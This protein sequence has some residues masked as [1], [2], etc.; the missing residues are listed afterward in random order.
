[1]FRRFLTASL[2]LIALSAEGYV[3]QMDRNAQGRIVTI[4]WPSGSARQGVPFVVNPSS[5]P[6]PEDDVLR[7]VR[8]SF[9][10]WGAVASSYFKLEDRGTG[11]FRPSNTDQQNVIFYDDSGRLIGA[12][13]GTGVIAI[14]RVNWDDRGDMTDADI[15]FNGRDFQF[16]VAENTTLRG[17]VDLQDVMIHEAGHF[18]GLDHTPL[19]GPPRVRPTMNPFNT[20]EMPREGRTLEQDDI[21]GITALYPSGEARQLGTIS[22]RVIHR[23]GS[24]TFGVNVV[25]YKA[26]S[27]RFLASAFSGSAGSSQRGRGGEGGYE[28]DGLPPGDY[29]VAIEPLDGSIGRQNFG[30]IFS[31]RFDRDFELEYFDNASLKQTAF[32]AMTCMSGPP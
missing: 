30:G 7:I 27:D 14:T 23:S 9:G 32:A 29:H 31:D 6:F 10:D 11:Q 16:S 28:I 8:K 19:V 5:F 20:S 1:M 24:G 2:L 17:R 22:G 25:V 3:I 15:I 13:P 4:Q 21:S 26:G 12:P 18:L